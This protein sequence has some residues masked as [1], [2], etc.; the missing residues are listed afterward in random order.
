M[1]AKHLKI[2]CGNELFIQCLGL[3]LI[4]QINES[5]YNINS[6]DE[7]SQ[8][9]N[10]QKYRVEL[11][12]TK[13]SP[14]DEFWGH[15]SNIQAWVE[16]YYDTRLIHHNLAFPLLKKL[17]EAGDPIAKKVFKE[18]IVKRYKTGFPS[19]VKYLMEEG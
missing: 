14:E 19:V 12:N 16:N 6:I 9:F 3:Y 4:L 15:C 7:A 1:L 11:N 8:E 5:H 2:S 17:T 13:L 10:S 18:E